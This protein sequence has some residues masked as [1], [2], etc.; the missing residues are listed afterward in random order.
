MPDGPG[1]TKTVI[2]VPAGTTLARFSTFNDATDGNDDLD[3]YVYDSGGTQV[4]SSGGGDAIE[5]V[6]LVNPAS[7]DYTVYVHGFATDG[8]DA[9]Y[10]LFA[11]ELGSAD[12]G[13]MAVSGLPA[14]ATVGGHSTLTLNWSGL[15]TGKRWLGAIDY[16]NGSTTIGSTIVRINS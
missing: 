14:S 15:A 11:W 9:N 16:G 4:G 10:T 2:N 1:T 5:Q 6:D 13:N 8:P 7:G 3:L 12:A